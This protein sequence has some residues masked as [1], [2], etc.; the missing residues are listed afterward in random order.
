MVDNIQAVTRQSSSI[1]GNH[2]GDIRQTFDGMIGNLR[3]LI[4]E[5]DLLSE[6]GF[7]SFITREQGRIF[8]LLHENFKQG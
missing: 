1:L 5:Q 6:Q 4:S 7:L 3:H 8:Y 2:L